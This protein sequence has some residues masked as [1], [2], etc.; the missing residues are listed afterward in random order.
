[1]I[2][3]DEIEDLLN[4]IHIQ[5]CY[6][7]EDGDIEVRDFSDVMSDLATSWDV[8]ND[9]YKNELYAAMGIIPNKYK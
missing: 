2:D 6:Y 8:L 4:K 5:T 9:D 7:D 1:M 3:R